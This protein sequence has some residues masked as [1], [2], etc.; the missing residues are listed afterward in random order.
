MTSKTE[1]DEKFAFIFYCTHLFLK[2]N[3]FESSINDVRE[4]TQ[5]LYNLFC[6]F[7]RQQSILVQLLVLSIKW[8]I[9]LII[10]TMKNVLI[11]R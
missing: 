10:I 7:E 11:Q 5:S 4:K 6:L 2:Q 3:H 1:A 8:N 9:R